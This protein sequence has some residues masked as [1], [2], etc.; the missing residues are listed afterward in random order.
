MVVELWDVRNIKLKTNAMAPVAGI[1]PSA[2]QVFRFTPTDGNMP[3]Y[4]K[5]YM[6]RAL[7]DRQ[8]G[9]RV[10][11]QAKWLPYEY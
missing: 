1:S 2:T 11:I 9:A 8:P 10:T 3:V 6:S 5:T 7:P 4:F